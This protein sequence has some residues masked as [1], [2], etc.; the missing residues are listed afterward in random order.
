MNSSDILSNYLESGGDKIPWKDLRYMF[1]EIMYGGH[2]TDDWDRLLCATYLEF[3]IKEELLDEMELFPYAETYPE[4]KFRSP[5]V[6]AYDQYF[7]YMDLELPAESP[8]AFGLHPNAEIAVKTDDADKLFKYIMELQPRDAGSGG[9]EGLSPQARVQQQLEQITE[10][11]KSINYRLEDIALAMAEERGPYQNVFLQECERMNFLIAEMMRSL[12]ELELGLSGELQMSP[13][14]EDLQNMIFLDR[15]PESWAK[16]AYPSLKSLSNWIENLLE[17]A[18]Q[19]TTWTEEPTQIPNVTNI[20]YMF[21]PQSF[22]TA[23][24]Q[25]T[26]QT[27][28]LELDK[29]TIL[30]EVTRRSIE[31]TEAKAREGAY[32]TGLYAE[33][34]RWNWQSGLLEEAEPREMFCELPVVQCKAILVDKLE[35]NGVYRCPVYKTPNRGPTYVFTASL[36]TKFPSPKWVLAGCCLVMEVT[37]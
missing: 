31:Q 19:L 14:M 20:A 22:L 12:K 8:V 15:V 25:R 37:Q 5:P 24:M 7:E 26:A 4:L 9:G 28:K 1:G 11:I 23:I 13:K 32:V 30:T 3:Y 6:L 16:L 35:T 18:A 21:N 2:I 10:K 34:A 17:R 27:Q 29:L 33:G 36:R